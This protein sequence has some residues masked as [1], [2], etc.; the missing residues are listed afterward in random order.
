MGLR[1]GRAGVVIR[2]PVPGRVV[3]SVV[4]L[5]EVRDV[6]ERI[7]AAEDEFPFPMVRMGEELRREGTGGL[8]LCC[9]GDRTQPPQPCLRARAIPIPY[10]ASRGVHGGSIMKIPEGAGKPMPR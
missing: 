10:P 4:L 6:G 9:D 2:G 7:P 8:A 1:V 3:G 5:R